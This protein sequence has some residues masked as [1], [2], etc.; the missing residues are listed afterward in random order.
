M[1]LLQ[2]TLPKCGVLCRFQSDWEAIYQVQH[3]AVCSRYVCIS[4]LLNL[5][6]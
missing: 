2:C 3:P 4:E 6:A 5:L 1:R